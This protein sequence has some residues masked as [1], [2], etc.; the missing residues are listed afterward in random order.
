M[1]QKFGNI[2][3]TRGRIQQPWMICRSQKGDKPH[4]TVRCRACSIILVLVIRAK[5]LEIFTYCI[6]INCVFTFRTTNV[7]SCFFSVLAK[8]DLVK[9]KFLNWTT[10]YVDLCSLQSHSEWGNSKCVSAPT[11]TILPTT[12]GTFR[13]LVRLRDIRAANYHIQNSIWFKKLCSQWEL[14]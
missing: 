7:F 2:L 9:N 1:S 5:F 4:W 13:H 10:L 11:T 3:V 8:F 6:V 12:A 14:K